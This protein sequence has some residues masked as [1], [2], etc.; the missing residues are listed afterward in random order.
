MAYGRFIQ[1]VITFLIT[2]LTLFLLLKGVNR[3][4]RRREAEETAEAKAE[5]A[6]SPRSGG[7][8]APDGDPRPA[9]KGKERVIPGIG[10]T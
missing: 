10:G 1:A 4:L 9:G 5:E 7:R 8:A 6:V 2:A 3:F